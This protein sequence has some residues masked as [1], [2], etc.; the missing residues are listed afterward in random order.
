MRCFSYIVQ[1]E[2]VARGPKTI[3]LEADEKAR[4]VLADRF[5]LLAIDCLEGDIDVSHLP[6]GMRVKGHMRAAVQQTCVVSFRPVSSTI[7]EFF[8][9]HYCIGPLTEEQEESVLDIDAEDIE[10][11]VD[12]KV[13]VAEA[14]AQ[15]LALALD[16]FPRVPDADSPVKIVTEAEAEEMQ[17]RPNPFAILKNLSDKA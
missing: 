10:E 17:R 14:L 15:T 8:S 11:L 3:H 6:D 1:R 16:P 9:I 7:E 5:G 2:D 4:A 13:D 12:D